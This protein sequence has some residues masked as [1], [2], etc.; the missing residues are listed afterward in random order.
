MVLVRIATRR[1]F[2]QKLTTYDSITKHGHLFLHY[3]RYHSL[4]GAMQIGSSQENLLHNSH[5]W[6]QQKRLGTHTLG[7]TKVQYFISV[8]KDDSVCKGSGWSTIGIYCYI[9]LPIVRNPALH[10]EW[11]E[12]SERF[13]PFCG[14]IRASTSHEPTKKWRDA[15]WIIWFFTGRI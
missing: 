10:H 3:H 15:M 2:Q 5:F 14:Q 13:C 6:W 8:G 11:L 4:S 1:G 9:M 12:M 7:M